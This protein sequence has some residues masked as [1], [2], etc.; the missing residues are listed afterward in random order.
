MN[1]GQ[2]SVQHRNQFIPKYKYLHS[3][4]MALEKV[5]RKLHVKMINL[6]IY[7]TAYYYGVGS[8]NKMRRI[9]FI[10][11]M[12]NLGEHTAPDLPH[13]H[14]HE[15]CCIC[16]GLIFLSL[17]HCQ[18]EKKIGETLLFMKLCKNLLII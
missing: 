9:I 13:F 3:L 4:S 10:L 7:K 18:E 15:T 1:T 5:H 2:M 6:S 11:E 14:L 12:F 8:D 17:G 16:L